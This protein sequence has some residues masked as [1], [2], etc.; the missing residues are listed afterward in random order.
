LVEFKFFV[1]LADVL[2]MVPFADGVC[3][4]LFSFYFLYPQPARFCW[5]S[6]PWI[7]WSR[8]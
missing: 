8:Q 2:W 6:N 5:K 4:F 3:W 1:L 7:Q